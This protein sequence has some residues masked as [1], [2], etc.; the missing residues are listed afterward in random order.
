VAEASQAKAALDALFGGGKESQ[1]SA[2]SAAD[3]ARAELE[4]LFGKK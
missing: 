3:K 4:A 2:P 1:P